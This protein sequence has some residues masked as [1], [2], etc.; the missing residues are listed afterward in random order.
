M[1]LCIAAL[2]IYHDVALSQVGYLF[3]CKI[4]LALT[5]EMPAYN[6][7]GQQAKIG[8]IHNFMIKKQNFKNL[9]KSETSLF[10]LAT[11][12]K[13]TGIFAAA[14]ILIFYLFWLILSLNN[15]FFESQG[16]SAKIAFKDAFFDHVLRSAS[17]LF[18]YFFLLFVVLF[19]GGVLISKMLLRPFKVIAD[20]CDKKSEGESANYDPDNF[21]DYK[22]LTRFSDFFFQYLDDSVKKGK[23]VSNSIP[24]QFLGIHR[25]V[26]DRVFFFHFFFFIFILGLIAVS[27]LNMATTYMRE[28][29]VDLAVN[30]L[31]LRGQGTSHFFQEQAFLFDSI[32]IVG[33]LILCLA[34]ALLSIHLYGKV[35]GAIFG[36][37]STMRAFMKGDTKARLRL[38]GYNHVRPYGRSFNRYLKYID[39]KL[40][41]ETSQGRQGRQ[42]IKTKN[43]SKKVS[44]DTKI[45]KEE[46]SGNK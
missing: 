37:F 5:K 41:E 40:S 26:F 33:T 42:E 17:E 24:P 16:F 15:V 11:G 28:D 19:F 39:A 2:V 1:I 45:S 43:A 30:S 32:N 46:K 36:F 21:S 3:E 29:I 35:S 18:P 34:Y 25:P 31:Q 10:A 44:N 12:L 6:S 13:V 38:L 14:S 23:L 22:L 9:F 7:Y 8:K 4:Y 20:Y 27:M